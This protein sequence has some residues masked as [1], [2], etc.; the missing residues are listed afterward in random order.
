M[1]GCSLIK[2][3]NENYPAA[4]DV[5]SGGDYTKKQTTMLIIMSIGAVL[6]ALA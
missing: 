4:V 6:V 1:F 3:G 5:S 2:S